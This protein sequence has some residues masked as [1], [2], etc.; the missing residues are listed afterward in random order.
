MYAKDFM[1]G[2]QSCMKADYHGNYARLCKHV[3]IIESTMDLVSVP[4]ELRDFKAGAS[5]ELSRKSAVVVHALKF[6]P[7]IRDGSYVICK[8]CV[9]DGHLMGW[10]YCPILTWAYLL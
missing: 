10:C 6:L 7:K 2:N 1:E 8:R 5:T 3:G 4:A 9:T